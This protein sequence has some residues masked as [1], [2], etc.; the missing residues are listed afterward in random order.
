MPDEEERPSLA[1]D[2]WLPDRMAALGFL[3]GG[4]RRVADEWLRTLDRYFASI[5]DAVF[6]GSGQWRT[7]DPLGV[8]ASAERFGRL[9]G[10]FLDAAILRLIGDAYMRVH[11]EGVEF[12][13]RPWVRQHLQDVS[14]RLVR[15]PDEV[16]NLMRVQLDDG[17]NDGESI[18][19]LAA[20]IDS[21][22]LS[23]GSERWTNR[24]VVIART[25][26]V[27]AYNG[28]T[29]DAFELLGEE[30]DEPLEKV[31][32]ASMD[33]RTRDS[34]FKADGQRVPL[35]SSFMVGGFPGLYPGDPMLPAKERIQ[36][37][38]TVLYVEPGE[39][40]D[41]SGRGMRDQQ[42][43]DREIRSRADRGIIRARDE[44]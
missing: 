44:E 15:V 8:M 1:E 22:L 23:A 26:T 43:I 29:Q 13:N 27:S 34:H 9:L 25:E 35:D 41:M 4:E 31:W 42:D 40:T 37:R 32:L 17:I 24:A 10:E 38:C 2:R 19:E 5:R 30:L 21:D 36:C 6:S 33:A 12:S 11:G 18:P 3:L 16:F 39:D 20:R 14:N 7:V 28:A